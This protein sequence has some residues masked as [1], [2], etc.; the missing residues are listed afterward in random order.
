VGNELELTGEWEDELLFWCTPKGL[1]F[2]TQY[3]IELEDVAR[4]GGTVVRAW[5]SY[6]APNGGGALSTLAKP[7]SARRV[8][9]DLREIK[10]LLEC[11]EIATTVGQ[12]SGPSLRR[13]LTNPL[14]RTT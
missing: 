7:F 12:P 14:W 9:R 4:H 11:G 2:E 5:V 6:V 13:W 3:A 8:E 1:R 10:Q